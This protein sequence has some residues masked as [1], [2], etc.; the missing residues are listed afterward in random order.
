M[1]INS[2]M[3]FFGK[4][5]TETNRMRSNYPIPL[6][7]LDDNEDQNLEGFGDAKQSVKSM[8]LCKSNLYAA[9]GVSWAYSISEQ[10]DLPQII[11]RLFIDGKKW[12]IILYEDDDIVEKEKIIDLVALISTEKELNG[13]NLK[14]FAPIPKTIQ[15]LLEDLVQKGYLYGSE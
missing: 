6:D 1:M 10:H 12:D 7:G 4:I 8:M 5:V 14:Q 13:E 15:R 9:E 2:L 11:C 3:I